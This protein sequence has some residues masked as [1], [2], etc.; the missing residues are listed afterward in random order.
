[1]RPGSGHVG[2]H[3]TR[4][5]EH[6]VLQFDAF[7][8][9]NIVLDADPIADPHVIADVDILAQRAVLA[10]HRARLDMAEVPY[11][12]ALANRHILVDVATFV[13][14]KVTHSTALR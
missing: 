12:G 3:A 11:L 7:V 5:A 10:N 6:I 14:K 9:R 8:N 4:T 13:Y 2:K 1:M